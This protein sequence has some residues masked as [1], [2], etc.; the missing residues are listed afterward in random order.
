MLDFFYCIQNSKMRKATRDELK[1]YENYVR[2]SLPSRKLQIKTF[3]L[4]CR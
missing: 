3:S 4:H 1:G 2:F